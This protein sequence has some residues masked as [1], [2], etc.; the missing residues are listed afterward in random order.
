MYLFFGRHLT[1]PLSVSCDPLGGPDPHFENH[2]PRVP[3]QWTKHGKVPFK[4]LL[5]CT[6]GD[7][8]SNN[9]SADAPL[10][11]PFLVFSPLPVKQPE[12]TSATVN[13]EIE[14]GAKYRCVFHT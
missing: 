14:T 7:K 12:A 6:K 13:L 2:C 3:F 10:Q 5:Q 1:T 9:L 4:L 11:V 8:M